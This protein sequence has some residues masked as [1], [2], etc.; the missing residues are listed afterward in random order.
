MLSTYSRSKHIPIFQLVEKSEEQALEIDEPSA[1]HA[2]TKDELKS[3]YGSLNKA[4]AHFGVSAKNWEQ[5]V[6]KLNL[7]KE[8]QSGSV[9]GILCL[10][11]TKK[12][13]DW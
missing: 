13:K 5:L 4:K 10:R 3:M 11:K 2:Y 1:Q 7:G 12:T 8:E 9:A 6:N